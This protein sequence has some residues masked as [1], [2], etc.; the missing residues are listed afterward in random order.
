MLSETFLHSSKDIR[1]KST[2]YIKAIYIEMGKDFARLIYSKTKYKKIMNPQMMTLKDLIK[3]L[4][5][6]IGSEKYR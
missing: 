4:N 5:Y 1:F 6:H 3:P 2:V